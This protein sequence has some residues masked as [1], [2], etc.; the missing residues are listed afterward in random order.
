M[1]EE[2]FNPFAG[3]S[4]LKTDFTGEILATSEFGTDVD[5][6]NGQQLVAIFYVRDLADD[7]EIKRLL[8]IGTGWEDADGG[9]RVIREGGAEDG[10]DIKGFNQSTNYQRWITSAY[11]GGGDEFML[12]AGVPWDI[13]MWH[14]STWEFGE[15]HYKKMSDGT[16]EE[17]GRLVVPVK[18]VSGPGEKAA[19]KRVAKKASGKAAPTAA[20]KAAAAKAKAAAKKAEADD[21][22]DPQLAA[23]IALAKAADSHDEFMQSAYEEL[24]DADAYEDQIIDEAWYDENHG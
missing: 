17:T 12:A 3:T 10:S 1:P 5:Y 11:Q 23:L 14:G 16:D 6:M 8:S 9:K 15:I 18:F 22:G 20:E 13:S 19:T 7:D 24:E 2:A 21:E 4:G